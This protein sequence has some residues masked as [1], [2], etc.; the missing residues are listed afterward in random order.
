MRIRDD[1]R[2]VYVDEAGSGITYVGKAA[3]GSATS[4]AVWFIIKIDESSNPTIIKYADYGKYTQVWDDRA[5]LTY[6]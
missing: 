6:Y 4:A 1:T 3:H 2:T 5:G